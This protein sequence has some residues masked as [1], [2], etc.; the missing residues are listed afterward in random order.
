MK[1]PFNLF[2]ISGPSGVGEDSIIEGLKSHL[3]IERVITTTTRAMREG[4]SEGNPYYFTSKEKF[5]NMI[6][7]DELAEYAQEYNDNY[8]GVTKKELDRILAS[9][10]VGIW[11]IEWKGVITAKKLFPQI[12][13]IFITVDDLKILEHRIRKRHPNVTNTYIE[14]RMAYTKE[15]MQHTDIYD[16]TVVNHEGKLEEA[17]QKVATIIKNT[18]AQKNK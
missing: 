13:T 8:Y 15:W 18:L 1:K 6:Q 2:I 16:H 5:E 9:E 12:Q 10:K 17:I 7:N 11:K 3:P 14:E 4:D